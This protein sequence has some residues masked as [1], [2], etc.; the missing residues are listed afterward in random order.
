M[1][2]VVGGLRPLKPSL[3]QFQSLLISRF[4]GRFHSYW[5]S[6]YLMRWRMWFK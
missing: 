6:I 3:D 2:S 4:R 5:W 1:V